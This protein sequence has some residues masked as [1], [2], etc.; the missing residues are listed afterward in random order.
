MEY[1]NITANATRKLIGH[2]KALAWLVR[3]AAGN[4]LP[5]A[6]IFSGRRGIGKAT[7]AYHFARALLAK[8][9]DGKITDNLH[10]N[11]DHPVFIKIA[12]NSHADLLAINSGNND[13]SILMEQVQKITEFLNL[14]SYES[15]YKIIIIDSIDFMNRNASN[16]LLKILE[17]PPANSIFL[18]I[19]HK[20]AALIPTIKSRCHNLKLFTP[21]II[22]SMKIFD[23]QLNKVAQKDK[24]KLLQLAANSPGLALDFYHKGMLKLYDKFITVFQDKNESEFILVD[25]IAKDEDT[26]W[27]LFANLLLWLITNLIK[28]SALKQNLVGTT[29]NEQQLFN[30]YANVPLM[31]LFD[32]WDKAR[33][34][35]NDAKN[36]NLDKK[37]VTLALIDLCKIQIRQ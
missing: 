20:Q 34:L 6:I 29:E 8:D 21:N 4:K 3:I 22:D 28:T 19:S 14:T 25:L 32:A 17:E 2:N 16:A 36:I 37:N 31:K 27:P 5:N 13:D 7:I 12:N 1:N 23:M 9:I 33:E 24:I 15:K 18:L 35:I 10:I 11:E 26:N 30:N